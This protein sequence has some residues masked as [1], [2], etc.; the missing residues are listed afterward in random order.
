MITY[1]NECVDCPTYCIDCGRKHV[2]HYFCD[3]CGDE[4]DP[5]ELYAYETKFKPLMLCRYC[6]CSKFET[7]EKYGVDKF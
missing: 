6:L 3:E 5:D 2:P 7:I 4:C 1:E